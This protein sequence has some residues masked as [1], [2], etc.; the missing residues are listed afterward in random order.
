MLQDDVLGS[1]NLPGRGL[2]RQSVAL[3]GR[4]LCVLF[5]GLSSALR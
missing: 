5:I 3:E 2:E 1:E 4:V